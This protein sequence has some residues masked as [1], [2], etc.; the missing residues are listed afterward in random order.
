MGN[1]MPSA[2]TGEIQKEAQAVT[3]VFQ[4]LYL[5]NFAIGIVKELKAERAAQ[6]RLYRLAEP[7][8]PKEPL[9]TGTLTKLG[10][11]RANWKTRFFVA[12][13]AADNYVINYYV[14]EGSYKSSPTK[15]KG[16]IHLCWYR[17]E[18]VTM[19]AEK[20]T[21]GEFSVKLMPWWSS[22]RRRTWFIKA[23]DEDTLKS[24]IGVFEHAA[25]K[26]GAP[27]NKDK[28]MR[29][30]F[31]RAYRDTRWKLGEWGWY[32]Y[33]RSES[34][35][36]GVLVADR[37]ERTCMREVY[38]KIPT[39]SMEYVVRKQVQG[40]LDQTVGAA[41]GAA[42]RAVSSA[43]ESQKPMIKKKANDTIGLLLDK[44]KELIQS[45]QDA[46]LAKLNPVVEAA[47][48]PIVGRVAGIFFQPIFAAYREAVS[49]FTKEMTAT[50]GKVSSA[51]SVDD[52]QQAWS[53][54]LYNF[55]RET[56]WWWGQLEP[57]FRQIRYL[58]Q[59]NPATSAAG[60]RLE[61]PLDDILR[62][63]DG[64]ELWQVERRLEES[65]RE[66]SRWAVHTLRAAAEADPAADKAALLAATAASFIHDAKVRAV[67]DMLW[68]FKSVLLPPI[69]KNFLPTVSEVLAPIKA[70]IPEALEI[71][72][73]LDEIV[74]NILVGVVEGAILT[75]IVPTGLGV[76]GGLDSLAIGGVSVPTY[77]G[78][79]AAR[80][81]AASASAGASA[82]PSA[83]VVETAVAPPPAASAPV[84][85]APV[86][87][88]D[89]RVSAPAPEA[90]A[91]APAVSAEPSEPAPPSV[92]QPLPPSNVFDEVPAP[93]PVEPVV[94]APAPVTDD[95]DSSP[96]AHAPD[97][98]PAESDAPPPPPPAPTTSEP[99]APSGP[100]P[101]PPAP[102]SE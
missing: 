11:V 57:S 80:T 9:K 77:G 24:W 94:A 67:E 82:A 59:Y 78:L 66:L 4:P 91:P 88:A 70:L 71:L 92:A 58:T 27:L 62:M 7:P 61:L 84:A 95:S 87:M 68:L 50:V 60:F 51:S 76:F 15:P 26:A 22:D 90:E 69:Q 37:C 40:V 10:G 81:D 20:T 86:V 36:L 98:P 3:T 79:G 83:P 46:L 29:I 93:L 54:G 17:V 21:Y 44:E 99:A 13:N 101:P 2:P 5:K 75:M 55:N 73:D 14:D 74:E 41:V 30:A 52:A 97:V 65:I 31:E 16:S 100:P 89:V 28:T 49:I 45:V 96:A 63:L 18:R 43:I 33:S 34:E 85:E 47:A 6:P 19:E 48:A 8:V 53:A 38:A 42:W 64:V 12:L 23:E 72:I 25:N 39:G 1:A 32:Y 102:T 56:Y 35:Q